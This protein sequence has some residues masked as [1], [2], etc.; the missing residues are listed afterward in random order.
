MTNHKWFIDF[1][2]T[3]NRNLYGRDLNWYV[4]GHKHDN[5]IYANTF[6]N[7]FSNIFQYGCHVYL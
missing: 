3:I 2:V 6:F 1:R 7:I 5:K 4:N